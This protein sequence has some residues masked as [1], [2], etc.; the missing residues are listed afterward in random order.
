MRRR[1][2]AAMAVLALPVPASAAPN[3]MFETLQRLCLD[4]RA[5]PAAVAK[6]GADWPVVETV[7]ANFLKLFGGPFDQV[8]SRSHPAP[9]GGE[10]R[11]VSGTRKESFG[12]R[13]TCVLSGPLDA[14]AASAAKAW[15]GGAK[16]AFDGG[17]VVTAYLILDT[18]SG[19]R[20]VTPAEAKD[21]KNFEHLVSLSAATM[22]DTTILNVSTF[23]P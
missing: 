3:T 11:L 22:I 1:L 17:A 23:T 14:S 12:L 4:T 7:P 8:V 20:A 5:E 18:T 21:P 15:T 2:I 19:R 10:Y 13:R 16:P 6:A 9:G